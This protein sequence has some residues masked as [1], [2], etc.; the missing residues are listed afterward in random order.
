[1]NED[2]ARELYEAHKWWSPSL[3]EMA[4]RI[5][6]N[7]PHGQAR[8]DAVRAL[9][10]LDHETQVIELEARRTDWQ[11]QRDDAAKRVAEIDAK[12]AALRGES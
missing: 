12:L 8:T 6:A 7:W 2:E 1:M 10:R 4:Q 9:A 3:Q 5:V 11:R